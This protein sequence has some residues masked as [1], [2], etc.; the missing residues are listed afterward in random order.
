MDLRKEKTERWIKEAFFRL[1]A[2]RPLEK[3]RVKDLCDLAQIN[4][5]TFYAHY[6]DIYDLSDRLQMETVEKVMDRI[7]ND[8]KF[9]VTDATAFTRSLTDAIMAHSAQIDVL[10]SGKE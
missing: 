7:V 3:I 1:R 10:F 6:Q 4:K 5:S 8:P 2:S 9:T